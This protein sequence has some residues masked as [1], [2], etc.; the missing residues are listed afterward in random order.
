MWFVKHLRCVKRISFW[1]R[2]PRVS[3]FTGFKSGCFNSLLAGESFSLAPFSSSKQHGTVPPSSR[4][5]D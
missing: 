2:T 4:P 1:I 5:S 3:R